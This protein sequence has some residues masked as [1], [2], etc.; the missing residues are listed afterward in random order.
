MK[1][2]TIVLSGLLLLAVS[3]GAPAQMFATHG[4]D[5]SFCQTKAVR[6]TVI[7]I[8]DSLMTDGQT[9]WVTALV[10][11]MKASLSP[12]EKTTVVQLS[13][14]EGKSAEIW[15]GCWPEYTAQQRVAIENGGPYILKKDPLKAV[16]EQ[17]GFF[18]QELNAAL[19]KVY[20]Q[21][22]RRADAVSFVPAKAPRKQL[23]R[24]L[25]SDEGR[26]ANS[27]V[28][29]RAIVYSDMAENSDLGT[30]FRPGPAEAAQDY[31]KKLG[32]HLRKGVFYIFGAVT[33]ISEG[34]SNLEAAKAFWTAAMRSMAAVVAGFG[35]DLNVP[36]GIPRS[37]WLFDA[38][39]REGEQTVDGKL[40]LLT[41]AEGIL[42][43]SWIGF[44]RLDIVGLSGTFVCRSGH[45]KLDGETTASLVTNSPTEVVLLNG[46]SEQLAGEVGVKGSKLAFPLTA[47]S[48]R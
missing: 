21:T 5:P 46:T 39:L 14:G 47:E 22:K 43:D 40:S 18:A 33:D 2:L 41:D 16:E 26:F 6:Q 3:A 1:Y 36:N 7:Y 42:V 4:L 9:A 44:N 34:P 37:A 8:D 20:F 12:G 13:P 11:K 25:A 15:S 24:A 32:T 28:T 30:I 19:S 27:V 17:Q 35:S 45:C 31:A 38:T 10:R 23:L 29:I 48:R